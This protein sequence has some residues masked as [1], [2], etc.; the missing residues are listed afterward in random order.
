MASLSLALCLS[1]AL[2]PRHLGGCYTLSIQ[3]AGIQQAQK[4]LPKGV[5]K[6]FDAVE[7]TNQE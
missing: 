1:L 6:D 2:L 5:G 3:I 4:M 7:N